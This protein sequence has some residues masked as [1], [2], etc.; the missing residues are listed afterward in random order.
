[1]VVPD[2][3]PRIHVIKDVVVLQS[4][5]AVIVEIDANLNQN[6]SFY[7]PATIIAPYATQRF[8][9]WELSLLVTERGQCKTT[10]SL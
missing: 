2:L 1:M 8:L 3:N 6:K 5:V 10:S 9:Y 7:D 4:A